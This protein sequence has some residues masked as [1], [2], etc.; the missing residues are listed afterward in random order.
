MLGANARRPLALCQAAPDAASCFLPARGEPRRPALLLFERGLQGTARSGVPGADLGKRE[1]GDEKSTRP[2]DARR[3][4][5]FPPLS[6]PA[7]TR[8]AHAP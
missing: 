1:A 7:A 5:A 4:Q 2:L 8:L 3:R 6:A